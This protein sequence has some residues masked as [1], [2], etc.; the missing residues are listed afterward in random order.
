MG[1]SAGKM[2]ALAAV[3]IVVALMSVIL[4]L[5]ARRIGSN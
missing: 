5:Y 3:L 1:G 4:R 2:Y